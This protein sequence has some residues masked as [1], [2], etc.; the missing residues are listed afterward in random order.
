MSACLSSSMFIYPL[1]LSE[2]EVMFLIPFTLD[3]IPSRRLVT[4]VSTTLAEL[5]GM[6]NDTES[7]GMLRVGDNF[8]GRRGAR[9]SPTNDRQTNVTI[10]VNDD[11]T[12]GRPSVL[13]FM[14]ILMLF[15]QVL[16]IKAVGKRDSRLKVIQCKFAYLVVVQPVVLHRLYIVLLR[17]LL[18]V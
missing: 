8:T 6:E 5:P 17:F 3:S 16:K 4:S 15:Q 18:A 11:H 9:A 14:L 10:N 7:A 1:P 13:S 2:V 12:K